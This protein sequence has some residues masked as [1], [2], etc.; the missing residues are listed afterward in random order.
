[1]TDLKVQ[2][3]D[4]NRMSLL[5]WK[6]PK[7]GGKI[8]TYKV[9]YTTDDRKFKPVSVCVCVRV[10]VCMCVSVHACLSMYTCQYVC[11]RVGA[12]R[13]VYVYVCVHVCVCVC[14]YMYMHV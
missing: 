11:M 13:C 3:K 1:M 2:V 5:T 10:R 12:C 4:E 7:D 9:E 8:D 14:I 6:K